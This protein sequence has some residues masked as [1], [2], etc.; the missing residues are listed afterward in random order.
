MRATSNRPATA[1]DVS[2]DVTRSRSPS[3][4]VATAE[5]DRVTV[6]RIRNEVFVH[7][8]QV[9]AED[10]NDEH[11][12]DNATHHV[13]ARVGG[14]AAGTVRLYPLDEPGV[15]KGDRLAVLPAFRHAH[16]G[17]PLVRFAVRTAS[18]AG[19]HLMI[20]H[21]QLPNVAF[22]ERLGW[23]RVGDPAP[24]VGLDHQQMAIDLS[25]GGRNR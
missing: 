7:E 6:R 14:A 18:R 11:D 12:E 8:Q 5:A 10:D 19:G 3:I 23:R 25:A 1:D 21:V 2:S 17:G 22:F 20:A 13:L 4:I 9:F 16:L 24:Y 15:W